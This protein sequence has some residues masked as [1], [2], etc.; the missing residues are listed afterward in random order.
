MGL[1]LGSPPLVEPPRFL[2]DRGSL[3]E[4]D[5]IASQA[6]DTI[7]AAALGQYLEHFGGGK[8]AVPTDET[9]SVSP[10]VCVHP[11]TGE[12]SSGTRAVPPCEQATFHRI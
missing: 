7:D 1:G 11:F 4:Q 12:H 9:A 10:Q 2:H 5:G 3:T 8:M 6:E